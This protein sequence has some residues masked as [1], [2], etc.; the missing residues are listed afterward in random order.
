MN[1]ILLL[2]LITFVP[3][4]SSDNENNATHTINSS[5]RDQSKCNCYC[6]ATEGLCDFNCCCDL[7]C[8]NEETKYFALCNKDHVDHKESSLWKCNDNS[9]STR[10][11]GKHKPNFNYKRLSDFVEVS[12]IKILLGIKYESERAN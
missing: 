7:D 5:C 1:Y 6:D 9:R 10:S 3:I 12:T 2:Q 8:T 11:I 4:I